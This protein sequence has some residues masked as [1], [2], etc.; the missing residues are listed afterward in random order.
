ML[1]PSFRLPMLFLRARYIINK[2]T[3]NLVA[4][5]EDVLEVE[6]H[7]VVLGRQEGRVQNDAQRH[8]KVKDG[9]VDHLVE[10]V[11]LKKNIR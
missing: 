4:H 6:A 8:D 2:T 3:T 9:I 10:D 7:A 1:C 11:L 5:V